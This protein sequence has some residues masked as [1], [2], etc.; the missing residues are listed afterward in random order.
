[1]FKKLFNTEIKFIKG[2]SGTNKFFTPNDLHFLTMLTRFD[3]RLSVLFDDL[4]F[5]N[6][7]TPTCTITVSLYPLTLAQP[8]RIFPYYHKQEIL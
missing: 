4:L 6:S 1:M 2:N 8:N 7:F 3:A 5:S